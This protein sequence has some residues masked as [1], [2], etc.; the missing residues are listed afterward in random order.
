MSTIVIVLLIYDH[1]KHIDRINLLGSYLRRD[2]FP[3]RYE[4]YV[5]FVL[6]KNTGRLIMSRIVICHR[7]WTIDRINLMG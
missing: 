3:L 4:H 1:Y 7:H 5:S 6:I 2:M